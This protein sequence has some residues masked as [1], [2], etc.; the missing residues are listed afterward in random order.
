MS[1]TPEQTERV[2][3][4]VADLARD[5]ETDELREFL[6]RGIPVDLVD[7][8]GNSLLM[9][10]AYHGRLETA[11]LLIESGADPDL[12]NGRNQSPI[13]G[14]IFKGEREVVTLL[15][16][17]GANLDLG[18]PTGRQAAEMFGLEL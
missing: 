9:L 1:L 5:G 13:A 18:T 14:A 15:R 10:A 8:E 3:A 7:A 6:A 2:L 16:D 4:L 12:C 11:R 17:A